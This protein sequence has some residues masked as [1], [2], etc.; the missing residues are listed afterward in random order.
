MSSCLIFWTF[1]EHTYT[2]SV[3]QGIPHL[4]QKVEGGSLSIFSSNPGFSL[5]TIIRKCLAPFPHFLST[6]N[7]WC[8]F[9]Y[10]LKYSADRSHLPFPKTPSAAPWRRDL[11]SVSSSWVPRVCKQPPP[12]STVILSREMNSD[13]GNFL[14]LSVTKESH[15]H[16][17]Q[18]Q[19]EPFTV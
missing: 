5:N 16:C 7:V 10:F 12:R 9:F 8:D 13:L 18:N 17:Q 14:F 11:H 4:N 3:T 1:L 19:M 15:I 6:R 2:G